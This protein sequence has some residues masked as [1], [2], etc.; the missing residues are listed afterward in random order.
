MKLVIFDLDGTLG[1]SVSLCIRAF[2]EAIEP[3]VGRAV[4]DAEIIATFGPSEEGTIAAFAP[5]RVDEGMAAY[6]A[7]YRRLHPLLCPQMFDGMAELLQ[8]LQIQGIP[9]ALVTGKGADGTAI[10]LAQYGISDVFSVIETGEPQGPV[11][12][13]AIGRVLAAC[14]VAPSE[15]LY[16]GDS[17][18][19]V[20]HARAAGVVPIAAAWDPRA[21]VPALQQQQP[22]ALF[23]TVADFTAYLQQVVA[24]QA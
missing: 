22:A 20:V 23:V 7:A 6:L 16:V 15:A 8:F 12:I 24:V 3:L 17:P 9:V 1:A 5:D 2:R 19:D 13:A 14:Q 4:S 11:K 10:T 21:D 18:S